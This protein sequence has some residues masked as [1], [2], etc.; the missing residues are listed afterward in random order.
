MNRRN[1]L[2][3][4]TAAGAALSVRGWAARLQSQFKISVIND[5]I[6]P[7]FDHACSVAAND[8]GMNW[9][10][11]RSM[12]HKNVTDLSDAEVAESKKILARYNLKV[13]DIGSPLF[14]VSW[15]GAP[16]S[17]FA[18]KRDT[19]GAGSDTFKQQDEILERSIA[20]AKQFGTN[21]VRCFDFWRIDDVKPYREAI[22]AKLRE[23]AEKCGRQ[24]VMLVLENE[25]ECNT[26]TAREAVPVLNA[27]QTPH[28]ALNWDPGN[29][30]MHGEMDAFPTGWD[31]LPKNRIHHC[32]CKNVQQNAAGKREWAPVDKGFINWTAQFKALK[33]IGYHNAVS[34]ETHWRGGGTP[35]KS[36]RISWDGM[37]KDLQ[38]ASAI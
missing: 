2:L 6:S 19:F 25:H 28:F 3:G 36:T 1:F 32:H 33:Q 17:N 13:T 21:K 23:A 35:E 15:P 37:K 7:D 31:M 10:E 26:A 14:K 27:I 20:L 8:F 22:N 11:L 16:R 12:W 30:V 18:G 24:G 29:A 4:A 38:A 9:I 5:E 34:L